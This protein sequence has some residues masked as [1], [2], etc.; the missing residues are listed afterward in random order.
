MYKFLLLA[1]F[2]P[3][4]MLQNVDN[5]EHEKWSPAKFTQCKGGQPMPSAVRIEN[6]P[7]DVC[8]LHTGKTAN[9]AM[10]F[11]AVSTSDTLKTLATAYVLGLP[12]P[13]ELPSENANA[14]NWLVRTRCPISQGEDLTYVLAFP[15][16]SYPKISLDIEI[17]VVNQSSKSEACFRIK[18]KVV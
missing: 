13:Y 11:T 18:A 9:M 10:D 4:V 8:E 6:C 3:A 14:C 7:D 2:I 5:D 1:A 17:N 15:I 16:G 12:F